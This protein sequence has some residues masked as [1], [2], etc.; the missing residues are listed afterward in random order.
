M[1]EKKKKKLSLF[2]ALKTSYIPPTCDSVGSV[3]RFHGIGR[4]RVS[5]GFD[6]TKST[7]TRASVPKKHDRRSGNTI[8]AS[9]P[10]LSDVG[11]LRLLADRVQAQPRERLLHLVVPLPLRRSLPEP[12]GLLHARVSPR[13]GADLLRSRRIRR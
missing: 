13:V 9:V 10:T 11:A 1:N 7:S 3:F 8:P 2:Q 12:P 4:R 5:A 6:G